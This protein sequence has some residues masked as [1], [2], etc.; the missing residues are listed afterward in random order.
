MVTVMAVPVLTLFLSA[1]WFA[2]IFYPEQ[3]YFDPEYPWHCQ[4]VWPLDGVEVVV[5]CEASW[6]FLL[7]CD[8]SSVW[9]QQRL[10]RSPCQVDWWCVISIAENILFLTLQNSLNLFFRN[11]SPP[12]G[13]RALFECV[14]FKYRRQLFLI[15][16]SL[17]LMFDKCHW[18][19]I[20]S[21]CCHRELVSTTGVVW[22]HNWSV[23]PGRLS[24]ARVASGAGSPAG[25]PPALWCSLPPPPPLTLQPSSQLLVSLCVTRSSNPTGSPTQTINCLSFYRG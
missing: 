6:Q 15:K 20:L 13:A 17:R 5:D 18:T 23:S 24:E 14:T 1:Y 4:G 12:A 25:T 2:E 9:S 22:T 16:G 3:I 19:L 8:L 11:P 10:H 21:L 7:V